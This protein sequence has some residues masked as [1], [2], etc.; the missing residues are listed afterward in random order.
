MLSYICSCTLLQRRVF[1]LLQS[2]VSVTETCSI[3]EQ[4]DQARDV[5]AEG[6]VCDMKSFQQKKCWVKS[7]HRYEKFP[8]QNQMA[9]LLF[10]RHH[11]LFQDGIEVPSQCYH[12]LNGN[13]GAC[14]RRYLAPN[15]DRFR[16]IKCSN[17]EFLAE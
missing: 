6:I 2:M 12:P 17:T 15:M 1:Q 16:N 9:M 4:P 7:I 14:H 3:T 13:Q 11:I 5:Q 10:Q 8:K